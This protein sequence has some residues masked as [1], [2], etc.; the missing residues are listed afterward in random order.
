MPT[1]V[2]VLRITASIL[3]RCP[4][5]SL[6]ESSIPANSVPSGNMTAAATTGPARGPVPASSTPATALTP[7]FQSTRSKIQH[8][9]NTRSID[10]FFIVTFFE[11]L[12]DLSCTLTWVSPQ[13][14]Q[15]LPRDG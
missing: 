1:A 2:A 8:I 13:F 5:S 3:T 7:D 10:P 11:K 6:L 14:V 12:V 9:E 4:T 15:N